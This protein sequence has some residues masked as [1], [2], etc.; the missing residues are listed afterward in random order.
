VGALVGTHFFILMEVLFIIYTNMQR[1]VRKDDTPVNED[2][3]VKEV[4]LIGND[5]TPFGVRSTREA[6]VIASKEGYDLVMVAPNAKPPVCKLMDYRKYRYEQQRKAREARKNQN[7][8]DIKEV[9]LTAVIDTH[10][11]ETKL[12]S[13]VKFLQKGDKLKVAVWLPYRAGDLLIQQGK[14]VLVRFRTGCEEVGVL[15]KDI[16]REGRYLTMFLTPKKK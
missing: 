6:L 7:I 9:R 3:H 14:E 5:G 8:V 10:D 2:I 13:G 4:L 12:R 1:P 16:A 11:F 15:D